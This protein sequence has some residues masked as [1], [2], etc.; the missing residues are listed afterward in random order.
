MITAFSI[1]D[2]VRTCLDAKI[3]AVH[4]YK[5][6]ND[7]PYIKYGINIDYPN[8]DN[9]YQWINEEDLLKFIEKKENK[10]ESET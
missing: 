3:D 4:V 8:G 9:D 5:D 2:D 7:V 10:N 1:G 6:D